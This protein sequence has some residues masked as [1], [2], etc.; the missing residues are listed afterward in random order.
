MTALVHLALSKFG[1]RLQEAL[2]E[3]PAATLMLLLYQEAWGNDPK[4]ITLD[5]QNAGEQ[6]KRRMKENG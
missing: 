4:M 5:D 1:M 3:V 6:L 2:Y